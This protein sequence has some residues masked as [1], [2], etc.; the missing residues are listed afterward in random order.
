MHRLADQS[1]AATQEFALRRSG[2]MRSIAY[3]ALMTIPPAPLLVAAA[4]AL[5]PLD[6]G[7]QARLAAWLEWA[8]AYRDCY[9]PAPFSL[10]IDQ[11]FTARC[12][13]RTLR[14]QRGQ[15]PE[16]RA[17]TDALIKATPKL[18]GILNVPVEET[19]KRVAAPLDPAPLAP[20][21]R[22]AATRR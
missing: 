16:Q 12:I 9:A 21:Q 7:Q 5:M 2:A 22:S 15:M 4:M 14:Q 6:T 13:E 17:A 20:S 19:G 18:V 3:D 8:A 1:I 11:N 10:R